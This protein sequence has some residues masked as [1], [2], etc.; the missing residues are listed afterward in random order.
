MK[1]PFF[2]IRFS[3]T[4]LDL[5]TSFSSA[6]TSWSAASISYFDIYTYKTLRLSH[7]LTVLNCM[8]CLSEYI[9]WFCLALIAMPWFQYIYIYNHHSILALE[10]E[11]IS[12]SNLFYCHLSK[13]HR[14]RHNATLSRF[15]VVPMKLIKTLCHSLGMSV[16]NQWQFWQT[17]RQYSV[18]E[19]AIVTHSQTW[20]NTPWLAEAYLSCFMQ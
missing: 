4:S 17:A 14:I 15:Y 18:D 6:G 9:S 3:E 12:F 5:T 1:L 20:N 11:S 19:V 10:Y 2:C 8:I 13:L 7:S 16:C